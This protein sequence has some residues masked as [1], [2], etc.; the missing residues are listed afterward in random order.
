M[1]ENLLCEEELATVIKGLKINKAP[2]ANSVVNVFL[3]YGGY[4]VKNKLLKILNTIFEKG[5]YSANLEKT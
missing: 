5:K 2:G 3:K 4:E 1:K